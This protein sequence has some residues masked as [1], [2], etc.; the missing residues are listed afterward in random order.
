MTDAAQ[1]ERLLDVLRGIID[2]HGET[3]AGSGV[4]H[5]P[6]TTHEMKELRSAFE[7]FR[8]RS[9]SPRR[10]GQRWPFSPDTPQRHG[11]LNPPNRSP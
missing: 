6:V 1:L 10:S 4:L 3:K 2:R 8:E 5:L 9:T 7:P 11:G